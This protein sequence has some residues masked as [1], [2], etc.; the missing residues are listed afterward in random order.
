MEHLLLSYRFKLF[1]WGLVALSTLLSIA[2]VFF[3]F[4]FSIPVFS[5]VSSFLE[6]KFFTTFKTNF[7]EELILLLFLFGFLMVMFSKEKQEEEIF[8]SLRFL[9]LVRS[10]L[11][12]VIFLVVSMLF[13]YG[14][15]FI[16]MLILN[17]FSLY[18]FYIIHFYVLKFNAIKKQ[19]L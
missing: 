7:A 10:I 5:I 8:A 16:A 6:T 9:A 3:N 18:V 15:A 2:Y 12:N 1:G 19:S 4:R 13:F 17:L 14:N 11:S